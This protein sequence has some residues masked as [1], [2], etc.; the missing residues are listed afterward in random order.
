[1]LLDGYHVEHRDGSRVSLIKDMWLESLEEDLIEWCE[2]FKQ[3]LVTCILLKMI[4]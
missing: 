3:F 1:M 2:A 4:P